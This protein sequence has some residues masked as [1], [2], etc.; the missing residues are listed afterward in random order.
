LGVSRLCTK[1]ERLNPTG[2]FKA[3]ELRNHAQA[4]GQAG[5]IQLIVDDSMAAMAVSSGTKMSSYSISSG[6][7]L[8]GV[9]RIRRSTASTPSP[10]G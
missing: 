9:V 7:S 2:S 5:S 1:V 10:S 8:G 3:R 6:Y 4:I